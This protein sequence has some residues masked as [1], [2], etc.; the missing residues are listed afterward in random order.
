MLP[1]YTCTIYSD[2]D[3]QSPVLVVKYLSMHH[4]KTIL[5]AFFPAISPIQSTQTIT[6]NTALHFMKSSFHFIATSCLSFCGS[7]CGYLLYKTPPPFY[8]QCILD[9]CMSLQT[10]SNMRLCQIMRCAEKNV[11]HTLYGVLGGPG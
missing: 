11:I 7:I 5:A 6:L 9:E 1:T 10:R 8:L 2:S 4:A 3:L